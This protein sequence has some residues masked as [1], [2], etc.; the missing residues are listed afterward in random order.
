M[1]TITS[2]FILRRTTAY[3]SLLLSNLEVRQRALSFARKR[4]PS[5]PDSSTLHALS[6]LSSTL[7]PSLSSLTSASYSAAAS[8]NPSALSS[9]LLAV[10]LALRRRHADAARALIDVFLLAPSA[11]RADIAPEVFEELFLPHLFPAVR[12]FAER[13]GRIMLKVGEGMAV[14]GRM[15]D[16][17]AEE[18]RELEDVYEGVMDENVRVYAGYLKE[19]LR[20]GEGVSLPE[21]VLPTVDDAEEEEVEE[22]AREEVGLINGRFNVMLFY[23]NFDHFLFL[24]MMACDST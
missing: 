19:V 11:A 8:A 1:T 24:I 7:S 23:L 15:S 12:W 10:S 2:T 17:Q 3:L 16:G 20:E 22:I 21:L 4:L 13:R 9:L 14:L 6:L 18:L 5:P